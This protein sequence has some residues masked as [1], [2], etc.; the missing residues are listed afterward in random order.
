MAALVSASS[1]MLDLDVDKLTYEIFSLLEN[2]FLFGY[3]NHHPNSNPKL[4]HSVSLSRDSFKSST[5]HNPPASKVRILSIDGRG[6]TDGI[7]AATSL[8]RLESFLRGKSGNPDAGI[9]DFFDVVAGSGAG[10]ILAALL[11]TRGRDGAPMF[12]ADQALRF[13]IRNQHK[14]FR[15]SPSGIFRRI[16]RTE[17][18]EK[19]FRK[20]FGESTLKD[21]LKSVLIPCYDLS[22]NAPFLFSRADALEMDGYDFKMRDVCAATLTARPVNIASVDRRTRIA[23]MNGEIAMNNPTAAAITHVLHNK[24]EF[25]LCNGVEDLLVVSLG[26]AQSEL[27]IGNIT[28]SPFGLVKIAGEGASDVV[29]QAVSMAFGQWRTSNYVRIQANIGTPARKHGTFDSNLLAVAENMLTEKNV[30]SVLFQGRKMVESTNLEKLELFAGEVIKEQERRKTSIL[31]T[32][33]LKQ[34]SPSPRTSS[35]TTLSTLSSS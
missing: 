1:P 23:A 22:T 32:V 21:T 13:L 12:T 17:K 4:S 35:A 14:I 24:L 19:L 5:K 7:L 33:V 31:A 11:F 9:A 25:P 30:E 26:N 10:G 2:K 27:G 8:A 15:S 6:S 16:I 28:S 18:A 3:E 20:T 29:D 34:A